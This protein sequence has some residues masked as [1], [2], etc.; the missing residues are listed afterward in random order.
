[1]CVCVCVVKN[2]MV[3]CALAS[4]HRLAAGVRPTH[5][6]YRV[7]SSV[8]TMNAVYRRVVHCQTSTSLAPPRVRDVTRSAADAPTRSASVNEYQSMTVMNILF[9][10]VSYR[11]VDDCLIEMVWCGGLYVRRTLH[12]FAVRT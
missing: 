3:R 9:D 11:S 10:I 4:V 6:A 1:M 8:W 5:S 7:P 2:E 12:A